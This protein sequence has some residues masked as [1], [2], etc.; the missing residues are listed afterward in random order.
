MTSLHYTQYCLVSNKQEMA[1]AV[2][3]LESDSGSD[4]TESP[5]MPMLK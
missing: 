1:K 2:D 3:E 4:Y 5:N